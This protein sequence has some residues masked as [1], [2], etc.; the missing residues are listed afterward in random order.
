MNCAVSGVDEV[1]ICMHTL[2]PDIPG[3]FEQRPPV[4]SPPPDP[5]DRLAVCGVQTGGGVPFKKTCSK[6]KTVLPLSQFHKWNNR[7]KGVVVVRS[8][9]NK[10]KR[11]LIEAWEKRNPE[12]VATHRDRYEA[13]LRPNYK[14]ERAERAWEIQHKKDI[15]S[16][17]WVVADER[18][19]I[20]RA[21]AAL[22]D[23]CKLE[24][25]RALARWR[26]MLG[27]QHPYTKARAKY[28]VCPRTRALHRE[29]KHRRKALLLAATV[30]GSAPARYKDLLET[31]THC[32]WCGGAIGFATM[33]VDHY[34]PLSRGGLH[35]ASNLVASCARC[36]R[37]RRSMMP[38][39]YSQWKANRRG[40]KT[41][42]AA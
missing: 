22:R 8:E 5:F 19:R 20:E 7:K 18:R 11:K 4:S 1:T 14:Q 9:C 39:E 37:Q 33:E 27:P 2:T 21:L 23:A 24:K 26:G 28:A 25:K 35:V 36:N 12:K 17:R 40:L 29:R 42:E 38:D 15:A 6:C 10:C 32:V 30:D 13:K 16:L 41:V 3:L 34:I 31:A